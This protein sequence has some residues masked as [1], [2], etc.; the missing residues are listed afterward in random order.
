MET[1]KHNPNDILEGDI[2]PSMD[3]DVPLD[4]TLEK[5]MNKHR[6]KVPKNYP[7]SNVIGNVNEWDLYAMPT[8]LEPK[9]VKEALGNES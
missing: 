5:M 3:E 4:D 1:T 6:S 2:D 9:N 7:I 8:K